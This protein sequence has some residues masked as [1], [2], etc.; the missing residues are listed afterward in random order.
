MSSRDPSPLMGENG[1]GRIGQP[2]RIVPGVFLKGN[3]GT[4]RGTRY[5][6]RPD[7]ASSELIVFGLTE[8]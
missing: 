7:L 5:V 4:E 1:T 8:L 3:N 2:F 6:M